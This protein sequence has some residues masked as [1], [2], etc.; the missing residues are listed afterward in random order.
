MVLPKVIYENLPYLYFL[1]S[2]ALLAY[3]DSWYYI[4]SGAIFYI[5]ACVVLVTRS[6]HR[7][8]DKQNY[9]AIKHALPEL[10]YEYLPYTYGA[11]GIF[12]LM[13]TR[14]P[15]LQFVAFALFVLALRN[16]VCRRTNRS[17]A[18][19]LF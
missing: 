18:K 11:I 3:G 1:L 14:Q 10:L 6:A 17:K 12:I 5:V 13:S 15:I 7:R 4:F 2:G 19:G 8:L 9:R 16:L